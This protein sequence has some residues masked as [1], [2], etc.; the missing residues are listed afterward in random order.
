MIRH[1]AS[2]LKRIRRGPGKWEVLSSRD[3]VKWSESLSVV[4]NYLQPQGLYSPWNSPDQNTGE[5]SLSFLKG[6]FPTQGLNRGL[7]HCRQILYQLSHQGSPRIQEWV[8]Y[9]FSRELYWPRNWIGLSLMTGRFFVNW[10]IREIPEIKRYTFIRQFS[11]EE[12]N[13]SNLLLLIE[14]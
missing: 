6:I 11:T 12:S 7:P 14:G 9:S 3:Q 1:Y 5:S 2:K 10:A 4:S 8:A 13:N